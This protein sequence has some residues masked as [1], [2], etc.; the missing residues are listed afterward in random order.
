[1]ASSLKRNTNRRNGL[2]KL[3]DK[4]LKQ[5]NDYLANEDLDEAKLKGFEKTLGR[6][7]EELRALDV[8]IQNEIDEDLIEKDVEESESILEPLDVVCETRSVA[9][10]TAS[11]LSCKRKRKHFWFCELNFQ[12][13]RQM[14]ASQ[15][16]DSCVFWRTIRMARFLRSF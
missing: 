7:C 10:R 6:K 12:Q 3:F 13:K 2:R 11:F 14:Q 4:A 1:M 9:R 16:R 5:A 15:A 8:D